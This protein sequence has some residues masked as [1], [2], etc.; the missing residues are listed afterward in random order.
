MWL[1]AGNMFGDPTPIGE[2][3]NETLIEG[4]NRIGYAAANVGERELAGGVEKFL[5]FAEKADFPFVSANVV[6]DPGGKP[7]VRPYTIEEV[8]V[9]GPE[10]DAPRRLRIGIIGL[11]QHDPDFLRSTPDGKNLVIIPPEEAIRKWIPKLRRKADVLVALV[12]M[13][14]ED[15]LEV[16]QAAADAGAPLDFVLGGMKKH[17]VSRD[18]ASLLG[19]TKI[20]YAG[21]LGRRLGELRVFLNGDRRVERSIFDAIWL[22]K[23][24]PGDP[25][26][27]SMVQTT[28]ADMND[29]HREHQVYG[30]PLAPVVI[31]SSYTGSQ[32]CK[33]CHEVAFKVW[34]ESAHADAMQTLARERQVYN[35]DCLQCHT[36]AYKKPGGY[37]GLAATPTLAD[38]GCEACHGAASTHPDSAVASFGRAG[39][40]S[41]LPCHNRD[42]SPDFNFGSYWQRIR[43]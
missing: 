6:T 26:I 2:M 30:S 11:T 23:T 43:H 18:E 10:D 1:D 35:P 5:G 36:T 41:C 34:E 25:G 15:A 22:T 42:N 31:G 16:A 29:W 4:M 32:R 38:V 20:V 8:Q 33:R 9:Q 39:I 28:L 21:T 37:M 3:Q 14:Y 12:S 7:F 13:R 27:E 40:G 24:Y 19:T 17:F